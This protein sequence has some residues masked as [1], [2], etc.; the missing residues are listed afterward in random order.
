MEILFILYKINIFQ[1]DCEFSRFQ[2]TFLINEVASFLSGMN[3]QF[4]L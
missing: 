3:L 4:G 1:E 2:A